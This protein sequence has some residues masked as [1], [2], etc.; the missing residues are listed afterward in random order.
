[1]PVIT[2][3]RMYGAGGSSVAGEVARVLDWTLLDN[4]FVE[5]IATR[6]HTTPA[7]VEAVEER[8]PSMA[9]RL[10]NALALGSPELISAGLPTPPPPP[11][12]RLLEV[13]ARVID[14]AAARG[15]VVLV[16]RGA[17]SRLA[18]RTD[19]LHVLCV[20]SQA[21]CV[22]RVIVRDRLSAADAAKRVEEVNH[23]RRDYV[24]RYWNR[25]WLDGCNYHVCL[26]TGWLG[27]DGAA[28]VV[29]DLARR[30]FP[31]RP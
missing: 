8:V 16:G 9:E 4:A 15:P 29:V 12:E 10:A 21:A 22:E 30:K 24:R 28:A 26:N 1:M 13:T 23:Q 27:V 17:Q 18:D 19:A 25:E 6:L 14:E 7:W 11:E 2:V 3:S 5:R 20:A 31:R